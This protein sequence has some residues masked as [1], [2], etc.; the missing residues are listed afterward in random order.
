MCPG[1][2]SSPCWK[3]EARQVCLMSIEK[4][5]ITSIFSFDDKKA[6]EVMVPRQ[7]MVALDINEPLEEFLD[8]ILESMHSQDSCIRE[9]IDNITR[10]FVYKGTLTLRPGGL[11]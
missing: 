7:D 10:R 3:P 9:E 4:E 8:E 2:K 5:M 11:P 6:K 1:K